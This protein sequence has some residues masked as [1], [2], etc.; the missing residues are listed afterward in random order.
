[1]VDLAVDPDPSG[2]RRHRDDREDP[3]D[4]SDVRA[5]YPH[6]PVEKL[7]RARIDILRRLEP[8]PG[9][10]PGAGAADHVARRASHRHEVGVDGP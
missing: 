1:M 4:R 7:V 3:E 6:L 5:E 9:G 2:C 8:P 10:R